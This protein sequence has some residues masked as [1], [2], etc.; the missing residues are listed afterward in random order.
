MKKIS[1]KLSATIYSAT[2]TKDIDDCV[3]MI[4]KEIGGVK[5]LPVGWNP[6]ETDPNNAGTCDVA[7]DKRAPVVENLFNGIDAVIDLAFKMRG[8][9]VSSPHEAVAK[10]DLFDA[11]K[12]DNWTD[13]RV[14]ICIRKSGNAETPTVDI[15]DQGG[16]QHPDGFR[17][18]FC[19]LHSSTKRRLPHTCGK[20]G[21]GMKSSFKFCKKFM[22]VSRPHSSNLEGKKDEIGF[23]L[24]RG[25]HVDPDKV[26]CYQYLC[27][28]NGEIIRLDL[29]KE[30]LS[31]GTTIRMF[32]Y[33]LKG[34]HGKLSSP[35]N[36]LY[37]L[38]N[39]YV[40][41]PPIN[42]QMVDMRTSK[43]KTSRFRGLLY[44]LRNPK[45]P[46]AHEDS[47]VINVE[48]ENT[49][50]KV[51]V[52]YFVL[53]EKA[54]PRDKMGTKVKAEQ[55]ITFSHNGQRHAAEHRSIFGKRFGLPTIAPRLAMVVDTSGLHPIACSQLYS[56]NRISATNSSMVY[57]SILNAIEAHVASD[58]DLKA[59]EAETLGNIRDKQAGQTESLESFA[60]TVVVDILGRARLSARKGGGDKGVA[61]K[62]GKSSRRNRKDSHLPAVPTRILIDNNP[63]VAPQGRFAHLTLDIDAKNGFVEPNDGKITVAFEGNLASVRTQGRLLGGKICLVVDIPEASPKGDSKFDVALID[64]A[65]GVN[66]SAV[67]TM[68]I[69]EPKKGKAGVGNKKVGGGDLEPSAPPVMVNWAD[70]QHLEEN[71]I[72]DP[73]FPGKCDVTYDPIDKSISRVHILLNED[74]KP[75]ANI[76]SGLKG[77]HDKAFVTK[78]DE[79]ATF[80]VRALLLQALKG[81]DEQASFAAAIAENVFNGIALG[82]VEP[83]YEDEDDI[84]ADNSQPESVDRLSRRGILES[85]SFVAE[86]DAVGLKT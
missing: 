85:P 6:M 57:E 52:Y 28:K 11:T 62:G 83:E 1:R 69:V 66:L 50:S 46:N 59:I 18:T 47:F 48:C 30:E 42:I 5:W 15:C 73:N 4:S 37:S 44:G 3:G 38:M 24:I 7:N 9:K 14:S 84:K 70:R 58:T 51:V 76:R 31:H 27:D 8:F 65:N 25:T 81:M 20:Y 45:T 77:K 78:R 55:G 74:F 79:Y 64:S 32:D 80:L 19:S 40:I 10:C 56:S 39:A 71:D 26:F 16:G 75:I 68:R 34:H 86:A 29:P 22:I 36:S 61:K 72:W 53:H 82:A 2:K 21:M 17:R 54:S 23:T 63:L 12:K 67:G 41:D 35:H 33:D 60:T 49:T 43:R 13:G